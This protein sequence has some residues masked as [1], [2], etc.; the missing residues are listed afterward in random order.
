MTDT[1]THTD[2]QTGHVATGEGVWGRCCPPPQKKVFA[3]QLLG[4]IIMLAD[5]FLYIYVLAT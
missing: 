3:P 5:Y 2:R 1:H 4:H